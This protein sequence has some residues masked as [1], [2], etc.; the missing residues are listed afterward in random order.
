MWY[1]KLVLSVR[2]SVAQTIINFKS[3]DVGS[4]FLHMHYISRGC[5]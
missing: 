5:G 1:I 4:S 2:L 3:L